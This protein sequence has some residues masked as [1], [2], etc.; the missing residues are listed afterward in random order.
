MGWDEEEGEAA[1]KQT[2]EEMMMTMEGREAEKKKVRLCKFNWNCS[3]TFNKH[4]HLL[5]SLIPLFAWDFFAADSLLIA[6]TTLFLLSL[7]AAFFSQQDSSHIQILA[8]R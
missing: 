8:C 5:V 2:Q 1:K 4:I 6:C 3:F 7:S